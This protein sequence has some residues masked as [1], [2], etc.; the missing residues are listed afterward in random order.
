MKFSMQPCVGTHVATPTCVDGL[1][2]TIS[3]C[4][5]LT[6][7]YGDS[8][9]RNRISLT[10]GNSKLKPESVG[11]IFCYQFVKTSAY[12]GVE[13]I[14]Y[15]YENLRYFKG[16][17]MSIPTCP[18]EPVSTVVDLTFGQVHLTT[19]IK[20]TN[21]IRCVCLSSDQSHVLTHR[22]KSIKNNI[23]HFKS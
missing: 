13:V 3:G 4:K 18:R 1:A 12:F 2:I 10:S 9:S 11:C 7:K 17:V 19:L 21:K 8:L 5:S 23:R 22:L 16:L 14:I 15:F 6:C 20:F